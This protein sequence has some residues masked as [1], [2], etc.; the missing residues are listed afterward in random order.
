M[1][2]IDYSFRLNIAILIVTGAL[3]WFLK[4]PLALVVGFLVMQHMV[5]R[6][7]N[8]GDDDGPSGGAGAVSF[9]FVPPD[10][11]DED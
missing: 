6:F 8:G 7:Q 2:P 3:T 10:D 1:H 5:A 9:G 11:D 4:N